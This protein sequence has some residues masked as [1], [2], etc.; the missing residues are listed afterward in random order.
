MITDDELL[1]HYLEGFSNGLD[2]VF[3]IDSQEDLVVRAYNT[4]YNHA[5][6]GDD[7]RSIDYL[8]DE[9][10]LKIIRE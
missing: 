7:V 9:E 8:T 2:G 5:L 6:I 4:G 3:H 1:E 10:T